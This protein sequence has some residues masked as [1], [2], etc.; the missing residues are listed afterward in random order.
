MLKETLSFMIIL[1][2]Y[3]FLMTT[4]F[5]TLFRDVPTEDAK[6]YKTL[7]STFRE[8]IDY[9]LANYEVKDMANFNTSH[10][11]LVMVHVIISFVFLMNYLVAILTTVYEIMYENGDFYAIEYQYIFITKYLTALEENNGYDKLILFPPP[12]NFFITPLILVAPSREYT[13]KLSRFLYNIFYWGENV[14]LLLFFFLY[15]FAHNPLIMAK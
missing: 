5:A 11:V 9:F 15:M 6:P 8:M 3:L 4:I 7:T 13:R 2:C 14:L 1:T 12:L 10:S